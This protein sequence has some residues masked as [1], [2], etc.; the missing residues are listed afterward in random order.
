M[1]SFTKFL[2]TGLLVLLFSTM[3]NAQK[4]QTVTQT[5]KTEKVSPKAIKKIKPQKEKTRGIEAASYRKES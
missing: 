2:F 1:R 5:G 3:A 4:E